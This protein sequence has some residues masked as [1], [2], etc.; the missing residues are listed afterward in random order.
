MKAEKLKK[1]AI[2]K[3][4]ELSELKKELKLA[5][6]CIIELINENNYL[7]TQKNSIANIVNTKEFND[8]FC[9]NYEVAFR[10][11]EKRQ[12]E[13]IGTN[14]SKLLTTIDGVVI[15]DGDEYFA[16]FTDCDSEHLLI[17]KY[18]LHG[19]PIK[20]ADKYFSTREAALKYFLDK[21]R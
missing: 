8:Y 19:N 17:E 13:I 2:K 1:I 21:Y 20:G 6:D 18:I 11:I 7:I 14:K 5:N 15:Y 12:K 16:L 10:E 3:N 9:A 4:S